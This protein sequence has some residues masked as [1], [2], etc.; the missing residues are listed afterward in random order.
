MLDAQSALD[1]VGN[2]PIPSHH[3]RDVYG[4][5][6]VN[7]SGRPSIGVRDNRDTAA[8][9]V[10]FYQQAGRDAV[11]V[12]RVRLDGESLSEWRVVE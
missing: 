4:F 3:P 11:L 1:A 8:A 10:G 12:C 2:E 6:F 9:T 5:L 7:E